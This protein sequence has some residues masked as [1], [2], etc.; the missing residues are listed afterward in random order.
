MSFSNLENSSDGIEMDSQSYPQTHYDDAHH[1]DHE[2]DHTEPTESNGPRHVAGNDLYKLHG[3]FKP[4][5]FV[6]GCFG[7]YHPSPHVVSGKAVHHDFRATDLLRYVTIFLA[8]CNFGFLIS[9]LVAFVVARPRVDMGILTANIYV[10][11]LVWL[12]FGGLL[13]LLH[14]IIFE[15]GKVDRMWHMWAKWAERYPY[16]RNWSGMRLIRNVCLAVACE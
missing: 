7:V 11:L 4:V 1:D 10:I 13:T 2:H 15:G 16:D 9:N 14:F 8:L 12:A 6:M 3:L 5:T